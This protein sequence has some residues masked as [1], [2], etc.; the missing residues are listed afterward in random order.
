ML[1]GGQDHEDIL[2]MSG[3]WQRSFRI[4]EPADV[5]VSFRYRLSQAANYEQDE[6]AE[7]L[8]RFD[9]QL[10]ATQSHDYV[11]HLTGDGNGGSSQDT[12]WR[13]ATPELRRL[14]A[15][16]HT[17]TIGLFNSKKTWADETSEL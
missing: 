4:T 3:G 8:V 5:S 9:Q 1:V 2:G 13:S 15:G 11:D 14:S 16:V 6:P 10:V 7:V 17:L 12:G